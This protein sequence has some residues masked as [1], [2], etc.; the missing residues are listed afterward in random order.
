MTTF[1]Y[2]KYHAVHGGDKEARK[3][4][5]TDM[6]SLPNQKYFHSS[7]VFKITLVAAPSHKLCPSLVDVS[8]SGVSDF[9]TSC[10]FNWR[11]ARF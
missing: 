9:C 2:E 6:V 5:Y 4:N 11:V 1:R 8:K 3:A 10:P 7:L